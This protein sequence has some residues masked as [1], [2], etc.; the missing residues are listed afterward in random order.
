[1]VVP[2]LERTAAI[3]VLTFSNNNKNKKREGVLW[4][5]TRNLEQ[6]FENGTAPSCMARRNVTTDNY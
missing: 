6:H 3:Y 2:I 1:M 4:P 5:P